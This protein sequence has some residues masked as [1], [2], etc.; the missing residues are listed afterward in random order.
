MNTNTKGVKNVFVCGGGHQGLSMAAHLALNGITVTLWNRTSKNIQQVIKT[1]RWNAENQCVLN[2][3]SS[4]VI[5]IAIIV[6]PNVRE[7]IYRRV[8]FNNKI[9]SIK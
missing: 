5:A 8:E 3:I 7:L 1:Q 6:R 4:G 2:V 9:L